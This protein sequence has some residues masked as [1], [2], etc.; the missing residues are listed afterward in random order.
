MNE[1]VRTFHSDVHGEQQEQIPCPL[2]GASDGET[3][4]VARDLIFARPGGY[5][6]L[7]CKGCSMQYVN[8][9][10]TGA[11]LG[12]H[13]PDDYFGYSLHEDAPRF[14]QPFL[15]AMARGISLRRLG[16]LEEVAGPIGAGAE[17][18]DVGCGVNRLLECIKEERGVV[19][20]GLDFKPEIV[21]Y[22][23]SRLQMPIEQGEL[24]SAGFAEG[25]FD[26]IFMMEY[27][28]HELDPRAV[29][30]E[31]RRVI[32]T[33]GHLALELPHIDSFAGRFFGRFW[34]NLD[35]PRHLMFFTPETL[36]QMLDQCGFELLSVKPF[37]LPLY[38]GMSMVQALGLRHW[39]KHQ[40]L[41]PVLGALLSAPTL[42]F[43]FLL[44]EFIFVVARA[45]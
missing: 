31:A 32:K 4:L 6:L 39:R 7:R 13:Y 42:P 1:L 2:C 40:A 12:A 3:V 35:I 37:T 15:R 45:K 16:Y 43:Q 23:R 36:R 22:V 10:P 11:A 20:Q 14:M 17:L 18:L 5:S 38:I 30:N 41:Y 21:E 8:P 25:R 24:A 33:G 9:R 19:G 34:W 27:L 44:P 28:E 26:T 29:L